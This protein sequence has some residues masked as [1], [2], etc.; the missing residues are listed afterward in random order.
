MR[1]CAK[2]MVVGHADKIRMQVRDIAADGKIY[3][4]TGKLI[5]LRLVVYVIVSFYLRP[6]DTETVEKNTCRFILYSVRNCC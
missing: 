2:V 5:L 4:D 1:A 3:V 6:V